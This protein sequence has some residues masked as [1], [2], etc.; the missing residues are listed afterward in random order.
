[1]T[2]GAHDRQRW[3][4][5]PRA[6]VQVSPRPQAVGVVDGLCD[7]RPGRPDGR[8][9]RTLDVMSTFH[10]RPNNHRCCSSRSG[11]TIATRP[12]RA[13]PGRGN[14]H[15]SPAAVAAG[16][17]GTQLCRC[18]ARLDLH[19]AE[20]ATTGRGAG[21]EDRQFQRS[22][23]GGR[24]VQASSCEQRARSVPTASR[25]PGG[26]WTA[27]SSHAGPWAARRAHYVL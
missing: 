3:E 25:P 20:V 18:S 26:A 24:L 9:A 16:S 1:M 7:R 12:G 13:I 4:Q 23:I 6:W 2:S 27:V 15:G 8:P 5:R 14:P 11:L 22:A 19:V 21:G 10:R 17:D